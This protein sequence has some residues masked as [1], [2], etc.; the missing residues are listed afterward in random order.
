MSHATTTAASW[1]LH[2]VMAEYS[3]EHAA[4]AGAQRMYDLGYRVMDGYTPF[5]VHGLDDAIGRKRTKL[6]IIVLAAGLAGAIGGFGM[7]AF[8]AAVHYPINVAG[9]PYIAW[10]MFVPI[11]F[12]CTILC[13][14]LTA[15]FAMIG[16]NGLPQP[17]HP[18][19]NVPAFERA[20][21]NSFF[22]CVESTDP[23]FDPAKVREDFGS[24]EAR[25]VHD[26]PE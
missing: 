11:T 13:A 25:D 2:G 4:V 15:V 9:R 20:S 14:S 10:P 3:D 23:K 21:S 22:V 17:Y 6:P 18:T 24:T 19:F 26:V 5:P 12:E 7:M 8:S 16:L 1:N